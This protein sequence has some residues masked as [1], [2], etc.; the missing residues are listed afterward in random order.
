[1]SFLSLPPEL[2]CL[3]YA[4]TTFSHEQ[5]REYHG[6]YLSCKLIKREMDYEQKCAILSHIE[7]M[8]S[9]YTTES[10]IELSLA[11]STTNALSR[12][13]QISLSVSTSHYTGYYYIGPP[14]IYSPCIRLPLRD[15]LLHFTTLTI[16]IHNKAGE[17]LDGDYVINLQCLISEFLRLYRNALGLERIVVCWAHADQGSAFYWVE[18]SY[19][20]RTGPHD[21]ELVR[22][23]CKRAVTR[24]GDFRMS[25]QRKRDEPELA[26]TSWVLTVPVVACFVAGMMLHMAGY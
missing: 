22:R 18:H 4:H 12:N 24:G 7:D 19:E 13:L 6:L 26:I 2:R 17:R 25:L 3:V 10:G 20:R 14:I 9:K 16:E 5:F 11:P 8:Q 15:E 23:R 1:M 21:M